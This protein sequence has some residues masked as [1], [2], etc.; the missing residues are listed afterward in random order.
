MKPKPSLMVVVSTAA[1]VAFCCFAFT[2]S[3]QVAVTPSGSVW[4]AIRD[5]V[6]QPAHLAIEWAGLTALASLLYQAAEKNA[7]MHAFLST[8]A[9]LGVDLPALWNAL[10]RM[11]SGQPPT[12]TA[13]SRARAR[14]AAATTLGGAMLACLLG[15]SGCGATAGQVVQD[16][17]IGLNATVC[18]LN[19][20]SAD[21][22]KGEGEVQA[23]ADAALTCGLSVAQA[24]SALDAHRAAEVREGFVVRP[25]DAGSDR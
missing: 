24:Q 7:R 14:A 11:V 15:C 20:Y 23:V 18:V 1:M 4:G 9:S 19:T 6:L 17:T 25:V 5:F 22:A 21:I 13:A 12:N 3:A 2:A 10:G 8:L 16:V